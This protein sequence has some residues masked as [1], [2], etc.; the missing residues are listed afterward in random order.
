V[1]LPDIKMG[2]QENVQCV[3]GG[4]ST[5]AHINTSDNTVK[6]IMNVIASIQEETE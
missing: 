1:G 4:T 3:G 2:L 6:Q 5:E